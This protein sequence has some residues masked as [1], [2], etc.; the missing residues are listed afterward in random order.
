MSS[1]LESPVGEVNWRLSAST[2]GMAKGGVEYGNLPE[3]GLAKYSK[4]DSVK[5]FRA[6]SKLLISE[7]YRPWLDPVYQSG[8][9][10][11]P[12][13]DPS[14]HQQLQWIFW[15][16]L[17]WWGWWDGDVMWFTQS[18]NGRLVREASHNDLNSGHWVLVNCSTSPR[19]M[20]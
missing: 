8:F 7:A 6:L 16:A 3:L 2:G 12:N 4:I 1:S 14:V 10:Q 5:C 13:V 18:V 19:F 11:C 9:F 15:S 17:G 20:V